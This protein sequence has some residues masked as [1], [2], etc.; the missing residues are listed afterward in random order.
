VITGGTLTAVIVVVRVAGV[1]A[2]G[3]AP[4][5]PVVSRVIRVAVA[6]SEKPPA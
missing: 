3:V 2:M 6:V 4:P 1:A 5:L